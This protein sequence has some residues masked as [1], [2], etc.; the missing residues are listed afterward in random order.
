MKKCLLLVLMMTAAGL[1][2]AGGS[3]APAEGKPLI[4][5]I[6]YENAPG[7]PVD[8]AMKEWQ[9][10]LEQKSGGLM[11][12][13]LFPSSQLGSKNDLID[14]MLAGMPMITIADGA[15]LAD[16]GA[17]DLGIVFAPYLFA[18]WDEALS[19]PRS[20]WWADQM[21]LVESKGIKVIMA[22][23]IYGERHTNTIK[24]I[25]TVNDFAG[26]KLRVP[27][28]EI[29]IAGI[30][31]M[32]ATATPMPLGDVYTSIQTGVIDGMENPLT[33]IID[34]KTYEVAKY[35]TLDGHIKNTSTWLCGNQFFNSL[36]AQQQKWLVDSG[37]EAAE[38]N[39]RNYEKENA[40]AIQTLKNAG[41]TIIDT[42]DTAAFQ[43]KAK[44]FYDMP[45]IKAKFS[46]GIYDTITKA[47]AGK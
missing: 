27:N 33:T 4:V 6:G 21:K 40:A 39:N 11:K 9:R 13:E 42:I 3:K 43:A 8:L 15:F 2:F 25:R 18:S 26:V 30:K 31:V 34:Q 47:I 10:I 23:Y 37:T 35:V 19:L 16:R 32:G 20:K 45:E 38:W 28:N 44:A 1:V 14:Q 36:S 46:P 22:N 24:P 17:P 41:V 12:A 5:Q 7:S 29:Q